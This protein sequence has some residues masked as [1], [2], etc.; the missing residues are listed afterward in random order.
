MITKVTI[1][2]ADDSINPHEL[3]LLSKDYP[4]VEWGILVS[5]SREASARYPSREWMNK[6]ADIAPDLLMNLSCHL[7]GSYVREFVQ[8][9]D[10]VVYELGN[11]VW[12][13]F[14][15]V[16]LNFHAIPHEHNDSLIDMLIKH[17]DKQFIFQHD[18]VNQGI[19][20]DMHRKGCD[21]SILFDKSGGAGI[22]PKQ[23]PPH[24]AEIKCGYAGGLSPDNIE[25][26]IKK[27]DEQSG[28]NR[29]WIDC[30]T[31]VRSEMDAKFDMHK[32]KIF[33]QKCSNYM[34]HGLSGR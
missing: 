23:W 2:G 21:V 18:G 24:H 13:T 27:I 17:K 15:R 33:L 1:T 9:N 19:A 16:Q 11:Y 30:E 6:L 10:N 3:A 34:Q 4:F 26:E 32:V 20:E 8:G 29:I 5:K 7:C 22:L 14:D 31:H 25:E 12:R 28:V